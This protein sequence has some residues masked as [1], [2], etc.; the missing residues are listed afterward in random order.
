[1]L[2][3]EPDDDPWAGVRPHLDEALAAPERVGE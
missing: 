2:R 3:P 1:M